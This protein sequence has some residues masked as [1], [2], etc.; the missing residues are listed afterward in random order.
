MKIQTKNQYNRRNKN[1][2]KQKL[3]LP[4]R[5]SAGHDLSRQPLT[6]FLQPMIFN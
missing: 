5:S 4:A 2:S 1:L 6:F 3:N